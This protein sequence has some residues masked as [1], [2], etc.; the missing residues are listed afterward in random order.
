M[1]GVNW[2][3]PTELEFGEIIGAKTKIFGKNMGAN[4]C[5]LAYYGVLMLHSMKT[6]PK[7]LFS[8]NV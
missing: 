4:A 3:P 2:N 6:A 7:V 1:G 8:K 5:I